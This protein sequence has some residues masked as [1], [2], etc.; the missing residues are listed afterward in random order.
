MSD[1]DEDSEQQQDDDIEEGFAMMPL[2]EK[3]KI[4]DLQDFDLEEAKHQTLLKTMVDN[5]KF[6]G[7]NDDEE[8]LGENFEDS[9]W[10]PPS[11]QKAADYRARTVFRGSTAPI[12][13]VN[14]CRAADLGDGT[15][16]YFQFLRSIGI[17]FFVLTFLIIPKNLLSFLGSRNP[18]VDQDIL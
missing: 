11:L 4:D 10:V 8:N 16:M 13:S 14:M 1:Y 15:V 17:C 18:R 3:P 5:N 9:P 12:T 6:R 7:N 2:V